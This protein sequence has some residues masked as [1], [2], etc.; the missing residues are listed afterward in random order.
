MKAITYEFARSNFDKIFNMLA[1]QNDGLI[2]VKEDKN[3]VLMDKDLLDS[4]M[5]TIEIAKD[6]HFVSSLK[7]AKKEIER[8]ETFT[9]EDV[10][11]EKL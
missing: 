6:K 8:G 10:F 1:I 7:N 11:S 4:V 3:F 2:I 5:E 9:F